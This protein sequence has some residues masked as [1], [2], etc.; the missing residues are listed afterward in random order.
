MAAL[1]AAGTVGYQRFQ[2]QSA[3]PVLYPAGTAAYGGTGVARGSG[4]VTIDVY[5]DFMCPNCKQF[6]DSTATTLDEAV[7]AGRVT[8]VTHPVAFLDRMSQGEKYSTRAVAAVGCA[9]DGGRFTEYARMLFRHQPA[10]QTPG[11]SDDRLITLGRDAG[12]TE[13]F[14]QCVRDGTYRSWAAH[15]SERAARAGVMGT[16]TVKVNGEVTD[17]DSTSVREA[18]GDAG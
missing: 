2:S 11:L 15:V 4:P 17:A 12:L 6:E 3:E 16:P 1:A 18:L 5:A 13:S 14:A 10:E 7:T 9:A 8:V